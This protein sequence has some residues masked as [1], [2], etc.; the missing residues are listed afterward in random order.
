MMMISSFE[1]KGSQFQKVVYQLTSTGKE[2]LSLSVENSTVR[3][4]FDDD[5]KSSLLTENSA[6]EK[7]PAGFGLPSPLQIKYSF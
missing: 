2:T 1:P 3:P 5:P 6:R 4:H 7:G